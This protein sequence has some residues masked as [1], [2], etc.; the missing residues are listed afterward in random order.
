MAA[1]L[2]VESDG[3]NCGRD[4]RLDAWRTDELVGGEC[5]YRVYCLDGR[6]RHLCFQQGGEEFRGRHL[7]M[8]PVIRVNNIGKQY[9]IGAPQAPRPSSLKEALGETLKS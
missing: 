5:F 8:K 3:R 4:T 2:C 7:T 6:M 9:Y 1:A